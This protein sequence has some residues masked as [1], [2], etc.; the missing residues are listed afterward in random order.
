[1][2]SIVKCGKVNVFHSLRKILLFNSALIRPLPEIRVFNFERQ[3]PLSQ[4]DH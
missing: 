4:R 3:K 1:M 2:G